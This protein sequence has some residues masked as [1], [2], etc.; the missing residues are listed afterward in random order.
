MIRKMNRLSTKMSGMMCLKL[1]FNTKELEE[2]VRVNLIED[3]K[4]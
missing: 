3:K 2:I 1:N 4:K